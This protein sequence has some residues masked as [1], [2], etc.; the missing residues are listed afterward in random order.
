MRQIG[1][2]DYRIGE[3]AF[4]YIK[5]QLQLDRHELTSQ[6]RVRPLLRS[7]SLFTWIMRNHTGNPPAS[8]PAIGTML[9]GRNHA[10]IMNSA[11][12]ADSL[13][14]RDERFVALCRGFAAFKR[15]RSGDLA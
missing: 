10:T 13:I 14:E 15:E 6:R 7:R 1:V 9:G 8:Y 3:L 4:A 12:N 11:A 5:R 2:E